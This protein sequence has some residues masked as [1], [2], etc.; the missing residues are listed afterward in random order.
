V[1][2]DPKWQMM[3]HP[4]VLGADDGAKLC[5]LCDVTGETTSVLQMAKDVGFTILIDK[6][7]EDGGGWTL[8]GAKCS[9]VSTVTGDITWTFKCE[10]SYHTGCKAKMKF[11]YR[12]ST[13][14]FAGPQRKD[15]RLRMLPY[16]ISSGRVLVGSARRPNLQLDVFPVTHP[17]APPRACTRAGWE[18]SRTL[19]R[20]P[21][22]PGGGSR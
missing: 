11:I 16:V 3:G 18:R 12:I 5:G 15:M 1:N 20:S 7:A 2:G 21:G 9:D 13:T 4:V 19:Q 10:S 14:Y 6:A 8:A 17:L 22:P